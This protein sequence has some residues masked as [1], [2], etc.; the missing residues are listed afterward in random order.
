MGWLR[1][2]ALFIIRFRLTS[3]EVEEKLGE[4]RGV[5]GVF[6]VG[7]CGALSRFMTQQANLL[8]AKNAICTLE[9]QQQQ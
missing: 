6:K 5:C 9:K 4:W 7:R 3:V 8:H 2:L 1:P